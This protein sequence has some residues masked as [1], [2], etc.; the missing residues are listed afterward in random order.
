M[1]P[2]AIG[3]LVDMQCIIRKYKNLEGYSGDELLPPGN[4]C[5]TE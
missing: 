3:P 4:D 1:L 2:I 5:L